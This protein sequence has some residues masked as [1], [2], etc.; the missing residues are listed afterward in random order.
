MKKILMVASLMVF[1]CGE[2][3]TKQEPPSTQKSANNYEKPPIFV[4]ILDYHSETDYSQATKFPF[5]GGFITA[6]H[7]W[8]PSLQNPYRY[9][10]DDILSVGVNLKSLPKTTFP[11]IIAGDSLMMIGVP[12]QAVVPTIRTGTAVFQRQPPQKR[13]WSVKI[14]PN[15]GGVTGGMSGGPVYSKGNLVGVLVGEAYMKSQ[16]GGGV[17]LWAEVGELWSVVNRE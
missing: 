5:Q 16:N 4:S 12:S 2:N 6:D 15:Q 8:N 1:G 11:R 3:P 7:A 9:P 17:E 14:D 10:Y 13:T